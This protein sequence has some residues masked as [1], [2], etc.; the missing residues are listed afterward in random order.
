MPVR[1]IR[2][3]SKQ[4]VKEAEKVAQITSNLKSPLTHSLIHDKVQ[5]AVSIKQSQYCPFG[6]RIQHGG[7][8]FFPSPLTVIPAATALIAIT[9]KTK[10]AK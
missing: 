8:Q 4:P 2:P 1:S 7:V 10:T 5:P 9:R 3:D 6:S